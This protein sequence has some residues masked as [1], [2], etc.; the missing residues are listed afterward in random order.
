MKRNASGYLRKTNNV[1]KTLTKTASTTHL[2][3]KITNTSHLTRN[4]GL[5]REL[6]A[7]STKLQIPKKKMRVVSMYNT[8]SVYDI[9]NKFG[10][11]LPK[12]KENK[13][14]KYFN[15]NDFYY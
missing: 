10:L 6:S 9:Q 5:D 11:K 2:T 1:S 15:D 7:G 3:R 8:V 13:I 4:H 14:K 12:V